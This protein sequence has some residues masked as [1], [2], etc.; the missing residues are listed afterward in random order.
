M[1]H[2]NVD[3]CT[4]VTA[5]GRPQTR[6]VRITKAGLCNAD[7]VGLQLATR[8]SWC[9][10]LISHGGDSVP[11]TIQFV[12][13][14]SKPKEEKRTV[15]LTVA[16]PAPEDAAVQTLDYT[17]RL[18]VH[19]FLGTVEDLRKEAARRG[20]T[21][22]RV[23][24]KPTTELIMN[25]SENYRW[26]QEERHLIDRSL[27]RMLNGKFWNQPQQMGDELCGITMTL[28]QTEQ[29]YPEPL[30]RIGQPSC[31]R[32]ETGTQM[33]TG[34]GQA[35]EKKNT[36]NL[37]LFFFF[38]GEVGIT[39]RLTFEALAEMP[40]T[41]SL[42][43]TNNGS[44]SVYFNWKR[45]PHVVSFE[46]VQGG[47]KTQR[48]YFDTSAGV[49][50]P[51][52]KQQFLFTFK[53]P[54]AGIF[55][56]TWELST[57]PTLLGG[58]GIQ[59]TLRGIA[60]HDDRTAEMRQTIQVKL[61]TKE[62]QKIVGNILDGI[63]DGVRTP[64]RPSTPAD[65][66]LTEEDIFHQQN[67]ELHFV[68]SAVEGLKNLWN[69]WLQPAEWDLNARNFR[70]VSGAQAKRENRRKVP[71]CPDGCMTFWLFFFPNCR[72]QLWRGTIDGM[73]TQAA[74]LRHLLGITEGDTWALDLQD[75]ICK[76]PPF[77]YVSGLSHGRP[78][79]MKTRLHIYMD[80]GGGGGTLLV[81][82]IHLKSNT[83]QF[84][85]KKLTMK[86]FSLF[87]ITLIIFILLY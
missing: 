55:S 52:D 37:T 76:S 56:E 82:V 51:G 70:E 1:I 74:S 66:Y 43:V 63:L 50:L 67:P 30:T 83:S 68:H 85:S 4:A 14:K 3:I 39:A 65:A 38:Q 21:E 72:L 61:E 16:R 27:P 75:D 33:G 60:L 12:V 17:G 77:L 22:V 18:L 31:V 79:G 59:V 36:K 41:S 32:S 84:S 20:D 9:Y 13:R 45:L 53:S 58:A 49:I 6:R 10:D 87:I 57:H 24:R 73:D 69:R 5:S 42:D 11:I 35:F 86:K 48:F 80:G 28:T 23:L 34:T 44:A 40:A 71:L 2:P 54:N 25:K 26:I 7:F 29:G 78:Q 15:H 62:T 64:E 8:F 46:D 81:A 47:Q 19:S